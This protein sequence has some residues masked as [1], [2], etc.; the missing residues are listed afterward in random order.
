M[1]EN[2]LRT[3]TEQRINVSQVEDL[4]SAYCR[5]GILACTA[6]LIESVS[7]ANRQP[8][9]HTLGAHV[10]KEKAVLTYGIIKSGMDISEEKAVFAC[11]AIDLLW[12]FSLMYDDM[13][14]SDNM[15]SGLPSA[16]VKFG[17]DE[18]YKAAYEGLK[19][20]EAKADQVFSTGAG[21]AIERLVAEGLA[22]LKRHKTMDTTVT[23]EELLDNYRQR[24]LF[25]TATPFELAGIEKYEGNTAFLALEN[26]N[27]AGQILNDLKD[28]SPKYVWQR[29]GFSDIRSGVM[30]VPIAILLGRLSERD[31]AGFL[32][33]FGKNPLT[34]PEKRR[35][36]QFYHD[37]GS[38]NLAIDLSA[39]LYNLS[40]S[41]FKGVLSSEFVPFADSWIDFKRQQLLDLG[42]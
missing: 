22:S 30:T 15:R 16:W 41:Q 27:L 25:H 13:A 37:S 32:T 42:K 38:M 5:Y 14:D 23:V 6:D 19:K 28:M 34:D 36:M 7:E 12:T 29:E 33:L 9:L 4:F 3:A 40:R 20:V 31:A 11:S 8:I 2:W 21:A 18:T 10:T 39:N 26:L 24:S 35:I 17:R 1:I